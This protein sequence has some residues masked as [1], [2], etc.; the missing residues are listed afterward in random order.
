MLRVAKFLHHLEEALEG[1][2]EAARNLPHVED[3]LVEALARVGRLSFD[4]GR[5]HLVVGLQPRSHAVVAALDLVQTLQM[6]F[7][8]GVFALTQTQDRQ[9]VELGRR[10]SD[11]VDLGGRRIIKSNKTLYN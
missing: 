2:V 6:A 3:I 1:D 10:V 5:T 11:R 4:T 8:L 7:G 9:S